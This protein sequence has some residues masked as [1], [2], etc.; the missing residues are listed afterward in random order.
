MNLVNQLMKNKQIL[1]FILLLAPLSSLAQSEFGVKIGA[2][3]S[4]FVLPASF[5][6]E[7]EN[8][9]KVGILLGVTRKLNIGEKSAI[10][11]ELLYTQKG[12]NAEPQ[13]AFE[14]RLSLSYF[15]VPVLLEYGLSSRLKFVAGSE[16]GYLLEAT[17]EHNGNDFDIKDNFQSLDLGAVLG[18]SYDLSDHFYLEVRVVQGLTNAQN[19]VGEGNTDQKYWGRNRSIQLGTSL[20]L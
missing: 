9:Y 20:R 2:N 11:V 13:T 10:L 6:S 16:V 8:S 4:N 14:D 3:A 12:S 18:L 17:L 1:V 15:N 19:M 5:S 7:V